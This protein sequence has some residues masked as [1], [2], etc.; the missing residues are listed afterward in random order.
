MD[1]LLFDH[2]VEA[3]DSTSSMSIFSLLSMMTPAFLVLILKSNSS[4]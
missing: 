1:V 3:I 4:R 2:L